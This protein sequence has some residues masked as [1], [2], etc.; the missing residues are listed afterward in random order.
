MITNPLQE[1]YTG[2]ILFDDTVMGVGVK[3]SATGLVGHF[4]SMYLATAASGTVTNQYLPSSWVE[5]TTGLNL[6]YAGF[7]VGGGYH[8]QQANYGTGAGDSSAISTPSGN[9]SFGNGH[10][11]DAGVQYATGPYAVSLSFYQSDVQ[12]TRLSGSGTA[13]AGTL[14][15]DSYDRVR[16]YQVSSKYTLGPGVNLLSSV[17]YMQYKGAVDDNALSAAQSA[18]AGSNSF[19]PNHNAGFVMMSGLSLTF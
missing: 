15:Q 7:T 8:H 19:T 1:H 17:G 6:S 14:N 9:G 10:S 16:I 5:W 11:F 12:H 3:A 18:S 13:A 2:G 4:S